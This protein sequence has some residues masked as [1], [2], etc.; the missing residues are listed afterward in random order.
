MNATLEVGPGVWEKQAQ[1]LTD[2]QPKLKVPMLKAFPT[3]C[4]LALVKLI[5]ESILKFIISQ[6]VDGLHRKSGVPATQ[7]AALHGNTNLEKCLKCERTYM[8]D[9]R[10]RTASEVHEHKTG[11][12]C[13]NL[14]CK[15][16]L[17]DSIINFKEPLRE[18]ELT[19]GY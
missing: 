18:N 15:G 17:I 6:N 12:Y 4:H 3:K 13:D 7:I 5:E 2:F 8:R 10:V 11:R 9:Y 14:T 16:E 19:M 1:G